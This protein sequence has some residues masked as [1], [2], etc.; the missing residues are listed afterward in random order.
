M[1]TKK[2]MSA[3]E[4]QTDLL[5]L[6]S[7]RIARS[8]FS[9]CMIAAVTVTHLSACKYILR[10]EALSIARERIRAA[11][12]TLEILAEVW[13]QGKR[14]LWEVKT[15]AREVL[16]VGNSASVAA[17]PVQMQAKQ[18][19]G[20]VIASVPSAIDWADFASHMAEFSATDFVGFEE[21]LETSLGSGDATLSHSNL[22]GTS[23]A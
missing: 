8:P 12:G 6:H 15:I 17:I 13:S 22:S 19:E 3:V 21:Y 5:T 1:H 23:F 9:I 14:I 16:G 20:A 2:I 7:R 4:R 11:I 18:N 10:D